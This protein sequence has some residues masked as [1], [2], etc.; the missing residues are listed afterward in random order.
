M[1][2]LTVLAL[3]LTMAGC[4][5]RPPEIVYQS[6]EVLVPVEVARNPPDTL[7]APYTPSRLPRFISPRD[8]GAKVALSA[9]ELNHLKAVLRTLV[10]RDEAWRA[11][12]T[13]GATP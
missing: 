11:W 1:A 12:A 13:E 6:V 8:P 7:A 2:R 10:T 4:S 3:I 9:G 5:G